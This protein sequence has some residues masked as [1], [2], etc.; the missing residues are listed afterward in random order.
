MFSSFFIH[1]PK[2]AIVISVVITLAGLLALSA[3]PVSQYPNLTPPSL[4]I[5]VTY[6]GATRLPRTHR[7]GGMMD[8]GS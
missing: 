7:R 8:A 1:R 5:S 4:T 3:I 2:F 6:P